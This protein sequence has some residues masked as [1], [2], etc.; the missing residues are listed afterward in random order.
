[1]SF[2]HQICKVSYN[3]LLLLQHPLNLCTLKSYL[4]L[5]QG[6]ELL[7]LGGQLPITL[8]QIYC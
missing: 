1:M 5:Q 6:A 8:V 4:V 7:N 2:S 3:N